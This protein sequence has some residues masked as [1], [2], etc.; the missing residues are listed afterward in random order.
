MAEALV[1]QPDPDPDAVGYPFLR[2]GDARAAQWL[3]R[4]GERARRAHANRTAAERYE[5]AL[6]LLVLV[7]GAKCHYG[8]AAAPCTEVR[9]RLPAHERLTIMPFRTGN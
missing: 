2:A 4:A 3:V 1:G 9:T 6:A 8:Q 5:A 7:P